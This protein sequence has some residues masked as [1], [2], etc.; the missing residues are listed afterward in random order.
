VKYCTLFRSKLPYLSLS[1]LAILQFSPP[2]PAQ[3]QAI[4]YART[5]LR[6]KE[7]VEAALRGLQAY[8]GQKLPI[9][10]GFVAMGEQPLDRYEHAFYQFSIDLVPNGTDSTVVK[11]SAKITAWY[12]DPDPSKAG[13]QVLPS[14]GR[15]ELDLLDRLG[16]EFGAKP[17]IHV[18]RTTLQAPRPKIDS[19][20]NP[21]P[22]SPSSLVAASNSAAGASP[23]TAPS[24][25]SANELAALK[26]KREIEQKHML[27]LKSELEGLEEMQHNQAHPSNLVIVKKSRSPVLARP[28]EGAKVL[29]TASADD[30]FEFIEA[31][32]D[33]FH[34]QISGVSRG[35]IR[36]SEA[37]SMDPRWNAPGTPAKAEPESASMFK[38]TREESGPFPGN[39]APL[40]SLTVKIFWVQ[41]AASPTISTAPGEKR[42]FTKSLFQR[43][44]ND[45][46]GARTIPAGV[47]VVFDTPDGGQVSTTMAIL[48]SWMENKI[49][50][51]LFW[52]QCSVDPPE[53]FSVPQ[54]K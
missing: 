16:E 50:G 29:F 11:L 35:W 49:P 26:S 2:P 51:P 20:G 46:K 5:F 30:E 32:G 39:W 3:A 33:W 15:L 24:A 7:D 52:Q 41:P 45:A 36:R 19:A 18:P 42:E 44:W 13:Y 47:V 40:K 25:A 22:E 43:A 54:K 37:E 1:L 38:V 14:T 34:I 23:G 4:P 21:L 48:Q 10:D 9:V 6:S 12:A 17:S 8:A 28:T 31:E 27:E 53:L